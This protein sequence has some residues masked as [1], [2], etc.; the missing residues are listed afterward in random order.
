MIFRQF[1]IAS[2]VALALTGSA[3][4]WPWGKNKCCDPCDPC[5]G[6]KATMTREV[7]RPA[8]VQPVA[9]QEATT[10]T[11]ETTVVTQETPARAEEREVV[12]P[13]DAG[14]ASS[15][16]TTQT[17]TETQAATTE[18]QPTPSTSYYPGLW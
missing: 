2:L 4:A 9:T 7:S 15:T 11:Q 13:Q 8:P 3:F 16:A 5:C 1:G 12:I 18:R 10:T 17:Q 6:S 14:T